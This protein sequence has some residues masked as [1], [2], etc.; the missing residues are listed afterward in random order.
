MFKCKIC[1][2]EITPAEILF[3]D[4]SS[5]NLICPECKSYQ[6]EKKEYKK[7]II[8]IIDLI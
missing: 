3:C 6:K 1:E 2:T 4:I 7:P 5:E 8:Q